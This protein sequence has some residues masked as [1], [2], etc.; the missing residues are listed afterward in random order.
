MHVR[1]PRAASVLV[2]IAF[3]AFLM[4][5]SKKKEPP[6]PAPGSSSAAPPATPSGAVAPPVSAAK[7]A[8]P[9]AADDWREVKISKAKLAVKLP[10]GA[11]IRE[12]ASG[13][14]PSFAGS[15]FRV[16]MPSG[17]DLYFAEHHGLEAIDI[18][19]VKRSYQQKRGEKIDLVFDAPDAVVVNRA[20][21]PPAGKYCEVT[22]CGRIGE[23]P[24]CAS[25][26]GALIDGTTVK[27][28]TPDECLA[29]VTMARS[30][31]GL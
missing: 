13:R 1:S 7:S 25:H 15:Y 30:I 11:T 26:A 21:G 24:I 18:V 9:P 12:D 17:Y 19:A 16:K 2:M 20:E 28:L 3:A 29:V 22:A 6:P 23:A 27:K 4:G 31:R 10:P 14:D 8:T 5:T